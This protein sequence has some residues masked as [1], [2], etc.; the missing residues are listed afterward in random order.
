[1]KFFSRFCNYVRST[2]SI[3]V[4]FPKVTIA[5]RYQ[6][7]YNFDVSTS[8]CQTIKDFYEPCT[9]TSGDVLCDDLPTLLILHGMVG[10]IDSARW[11]AFALSHY[12]SKLSKDRPYRILSISRPG[13]LSSQPMCHSFADEAQILDQICEHF[14]LKQVA[15]MAVSSSGPT[16]LTFARDYPNRV[17][18]KSNLGGFVI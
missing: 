16:A 18:G 7:Q 11:H 9:L 10:G 8:S 6:I 15:V 5:S 13:Y 17:K 1:M 3:L 12:Q 2:S 14:N 4:N